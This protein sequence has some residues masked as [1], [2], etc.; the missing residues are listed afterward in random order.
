MDRALTAFPLSPIVL[1]YL[2]TSSK[3]QA[4][5]EVEVEVHPPSLPASA[6][7]CCLQNLQKR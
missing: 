5:A 7:P 3:K 4:R 6:W 1:R 2:T